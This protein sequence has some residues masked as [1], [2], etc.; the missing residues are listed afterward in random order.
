MGAFID[1]GGAFEELGW[2]GFMLPILQ[3]KLGSPLKAT[4]ALSLVWWAWHLPRDVPDLLLG[5]GL[6]VYLESQVTFF[7]LIVALAILATNFVNMTGGSVLPAIMIHGGTNLWSKALDVGVVHQGA[8]LGDA[9]TALV[10]AFAI[11][12]LIVAGPRLS[13]EKGATGDRLRPI[14]AAAAK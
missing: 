9:R 14:T 8:W 2:R 6:A 13:Y 4:L 10:Y 5:R 11:L 12:T 3:E 1:E 7:T